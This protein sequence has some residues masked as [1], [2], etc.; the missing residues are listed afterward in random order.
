MKKPQKNA[1]VFS[2][3]SCDFI[4]SKQSDWSRHILTSK[5]LNRTFLNEKTSK[6][7][8]YICCCGKEYKARN[9]LWYH[10]KKCNL[11]KP[12]NISINENSII[13]N[14]N[15]H[16]IIADTNNSNDDFTIDKE[17]VM[18]VLKQNNDILKQN[19]DLQTQVMELLKNG[20]HNTNSHN[21][22]FN[23]NFFLNE[24]CKNAM[25]IMD[26]VNS[27]QLQLSDLEKM[28][29]IGYVN[30]MSNIIIKNLKDMDVTERP[31][32]CTDMKR[33]VLYVKDEDKWDKETVGK[34]KIRKAIKYVARK[35]ARLLQEFKAKHPDCI[36]SES[37]YSDT[38]NKLMIEA[39]GGKGCDD[40]EQEGKIIKKLAK[41]VTIE[42]SKQLQ[43]T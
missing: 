7:A 37:K 29:D 13:N 20:T 27:L 24:T 31:V 8:D 35:N 40:T 2:C 33:E 21:K 12:A 3:K 1:D 41:E 32:H 5:H 26:F 38:Y 25:N 11:Q 23:L 6:N 9:S 30:G 16:V 17:F 36:N 4:C 42:N 34:P 43:L 28:G 39:M 15:D 14:I 19:N 18:S 22:N 10:K